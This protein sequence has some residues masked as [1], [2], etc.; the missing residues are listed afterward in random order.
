M[1][2][3]GK[4]SPLGKLI[5]KRG[6]IIL[7]DLSKPVDIRLINN[8]DDNIKIGE[9]F[10][11]ENDIG[12]FAHKINYFIDEK[13]LNT[14]MKSYDK[15][16]KSNLRMSFISD[17]IYNTGDD[18]NKL[19]TLTFCFLA[20]KISTSDNINMLVRDLKIYSLNK[21]R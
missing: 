16:N 20:R 11:I 15:S 7:P 6:K 12:I 5:I 4:P 10:L 2:E 21:I 8:R 19:T 9:A 13:Y 14:K 18:I 1:L 3:W 17:D